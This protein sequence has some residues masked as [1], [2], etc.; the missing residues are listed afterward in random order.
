MWFCLAFTL[1]QCQLLPLGGYQHDIVFPSITGDVHT[2]TVN[3][4]QPIREA[5][6]GFHLNPPP[7]LPFL[8]SFPINQILPAVRDAWRSGRAQHGRNA[9][10][11][12]PIFHLFTPNTV[13]TQRPE[14]AAQDEEYRKFLKEEAEEAEKEKHENDIT[15]NFRNFD[16]DE[17]TS[18]GPNSKT[19]VRF[20]VE[21]KNYSYS[22]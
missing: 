15:T 16:E 1:S 3:Y 11:P 8:Q 12:A 10:P 5:S 9:F 22:T 7:P 17:V 21:G 6:A 4:R 18:I 14:S 20:S 13:R 2:A 19:F